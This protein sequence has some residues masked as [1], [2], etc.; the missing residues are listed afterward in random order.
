MSMAT[1]EFVWYLVFMFLLAGYVIL[2]GFD[3]GVGVLHLFAR[4]DVERRIFLNAIGPVWDGNEVWLVVFGGALFAGFPHAYATLMSAFYIPVMVFLAALILRAVSI[5]F[6]SKTAAKIWRAFWDSIF[7]LSSTAISFGLGFVLGNM[8]QG[9]PLSADGEF[10]GTFAQMINPYSML[11]GLLIVA[12]NAMHGNIY[13][14]MK[15]EGDVHEHMRHW[16]YRTIAMF[17]LFYFITTCATLIHLPYM[18]AV[19][20]DEPWMFAI[21]LVGLLAIAAIPREIRKKRD[22]WAFIASSLGIF[23]LVAVYAL[24]TFPNL[25]I[26]SNDPALS[27]TISNSYTSKKTLEVL[28]TIVLIGMPLVLLYFITVYTIFRGKVKLDSHSY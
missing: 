25:V 15:T 14:L 13:L 24:G 10:A 9:I 18:T 26:A 22:G 21:V 8:I 17:I 4:S 12:L 19:F 6:R 16:S 1:L 27:L 7:M 11:T 23:F 5:E 3:L 20:R 2:D 28:L